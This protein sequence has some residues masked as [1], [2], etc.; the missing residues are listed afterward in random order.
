MDKI[1]VVVPIYNAEKYLENCINSILEQTYKNIE[2]ILV[3]DGSSDA[4]LNI[5]EKFQ[6]EYSN[7]KVIN[8][9]NEGV[10][11]ARKEGIKEAEGQW[12]AFVDSDDTIENNMYEAMFDTLQRNKANLAVLKQYTV[13]PTRFIKEECISSFDAQKALCELTFPS[14][15]WCGIYPASIAKKIMLDD[16]IQFFED[17]LYNYIVLQNVEK[18]ALCDGNYYHYTEN[19]KSINHQ[20]INDKRMSCLKIAQRIMP[21]GEYYCKEMEPYIPFVIAHCLIANLVI[22]KPNAKEERKYYPVL[23][24]Y[25]RQYGKLIEK[26]NCVPK[27]YKML[28][29]ITKISPTIVSYIMVIK[30]FR[31]KK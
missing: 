6:K 7:I 21:G 1:S 15:M 27:S 16:S 26:S 11:K 24:E 25:S 28:M 13:I 3:N 29:A 9:K 8:K 23:K 14:S 31:R 12:I 22:L 17:F 20:K 10:T 30:K 5:C 2:L 4:S 18:I 19:E